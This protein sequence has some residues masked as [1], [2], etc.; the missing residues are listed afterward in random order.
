MVQDLSRRRYGIVGGGLSGLA[1]AWYL[2]ERGAETHVFE[3]AA[4]LGGRALSGRLGERT[5]TLGGKNIGR[6]YSR[7]RSFA[8]DLGT[9]SYDYFGINSSRVI[10]GRTITFDSKNRRGMLKHLSGV[11]AS[12]IARVG[13]ILFTIRRNQDARFLSSESCQALTRRYGDDTLE[14]VFSS[15]LRDL[16]IRSL[17]VRV[18]AAEPDEVPMANVFPYLSMLSDS[19]DQLSEGMQAVISAAATRSKVETATTVTR[20]LVD[21]DRVTGV[22]V[23][24]PADTQRREGFDGI[25]IATHAGAAASLLAPTAPAGA[26]LLK[27]VRYFP[28]AVLLVEY[29]REVFDSDV[30]A[31]VFGAEE[32]LSNAGA[33]GAGD[34]KTVRYTFSGRRARELAEQEPDPERLAAMAEKTLA[35]HANVEGN[36]RRAL[37]AHRFSPGLCAYHPDQ[38]GFLRR[39]ES[40]VAAIPGLALSGDYLRGC[41]IEACFAASE[42]AV[43]R[44]RPMGGWQNAQ[45]AG[46]RPAP[47]DPDP[48]APAALQPHRHP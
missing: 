30:R 28:L 46:P 15:R 29:E 44:I 42:Q 43:A 20:L 19:Y 32:A 35:A 8:A 13:K 7:F 9:Q 10:D 14:D 39:I 45:D 26:V 25:V 27:E 3:S 2:Q 37:L 4:E 31:I 23:S 47:V 6:S 17:T 24:G 22:E 5:V 34:L 38:A 41:S 1:A 33:Y 12:E 36:P 11:P 48:R 21:H 40:A 18:S 16:L